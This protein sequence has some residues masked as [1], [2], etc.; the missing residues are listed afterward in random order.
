MSSL[1]KGD[2][3]ITIG[4]LHGDVYELDKQNNTVTLDC[5]G[6]YL[7]FDLGAIMRVVPAGQETSQA[8]ADKKPAEK[9]AASSEADSADDQASSSAESAASEQAADSAEASEK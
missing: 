2:H 9:S 1:K 7:K 3:V 6:I 5:E 4:R 8:A